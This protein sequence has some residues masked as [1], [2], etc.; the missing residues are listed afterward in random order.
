MVRWEVM[1]FIYENKLKYATILLKI[2]ESVTRRCMNRKMKSFVIIAIMCVLII[3]VFSGCSLISGEHVTEEKLV[4]R[5]EGRYGKEQ[6]S[7]REVDSKTW[8]VSLTKYPKIKYCVKE[9]IGKSSIFLVP[10]YKVT[11]DRMEKVG[12]Q[13]AA[14]YFSVDEMKNIKYFTGMIE[15]RWDIKVNQDISNLSSKIDAFCRDMEDN[16]SQIVDDAVVNVFFCETP[17]VL[18][19]HGEKKADKKG[20]AD[21]KSGFD[22]RYRDVSADVA[23]KFPV[24]EYDD[25]Q[26]LELTAEES[27]YGIKLN[28]FLLS[29]YFEFKNEN[30]VMDKIQLI[31]SELRRYIKEQPMLIYMDYPRNEKE[32]EPPILTKLSIRL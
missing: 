24:A 20:E 28:G 25:S 11:D 13:V 8:E 10:E 29:R 27:V 6:F 31:R 19:G 26:S 17:L 14:K 4:K 12:K 32:V 15:I 9:K 1:Q 7:V 21:D 23:N 16:Y 18:S 2:S 5:L 3:A 22:T 30:D